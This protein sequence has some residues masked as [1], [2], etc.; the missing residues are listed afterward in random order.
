ME[1]IGGFFSKVGRS[2]ADF[3]T[4]VGRLALFAVSIHRWM[5][6]K[7]FD[8][9]ALFQQMVRVGVDTIPVAMT[10][11]FFTGM[12]L[13]LQSG[14]TLE[15]MMK[16]V[17]QFVGSIVSLSMV[18][19]LGPVLTA[20][21]ASGRVG[22]SVAAE[23]GT[24]KVTEQVDALHTLAANPVQYL[25]VPRY[26]AFALMMPILTIFADLTGW[27]GGMLVAVLRLSSSSTV[28]VDAT[29][30]TVAV[31]DVLGGLFKAF[32]FGAAIAVVSCYE[33]FHTEGGAEGVGRSTTNAV[34]VSFMVV[35]VSDYFLT[36]FLTMLHW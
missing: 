35:L 19:E 5:F 9:R 12:V 32:F 11:A 16:G 1:R 2:S 15:S 27:L 22:S 29:L 31:G 36:A 8:K 3:L 30:Q 24:M 21:I 33:G 6:R 23:I 28:Y 26:I 7:P 18:R 25:A 20:L 34:V 10:T 14:Y 17:S 13:A 4:D